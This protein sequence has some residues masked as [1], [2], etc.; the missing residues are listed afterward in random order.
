MEVITVLCLTPVG[1]IAGIVIGVSA[2]VI[3][4]AVIIVVLIIVYFRVQ[5]EV[6]M[7]YSAAWVKCWCVGVLSSGQLPQVS[8]EMHAYTEP[9][10]I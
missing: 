3:I 7:I 4:V 6:R 1:E 10:R 9:C 2:A 5:E 8:Q